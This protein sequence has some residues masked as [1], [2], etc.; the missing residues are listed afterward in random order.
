MVTNLSENSPL[1]SARTLVL[2]FCLVKPFAIGQCPTA[3][4]FHILGNLVMQSHG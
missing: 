3:T 2:L 4:H 1:Y